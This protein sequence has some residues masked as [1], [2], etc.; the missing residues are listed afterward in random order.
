MTKLIVNTKKSYP[1]YIE[2]N[3]L[4]TGELIIQ[5]CQRLANTW[6]I[7]A[8][9]KLTE[10][11]AKPLLKKLQQTNS[12]TYLL[13][14][15]ACEANKTREQKQLLEDE[16][17]RLGCGRDIC[18]IALGGGVTTDLV[19]FLAAT[20]CRGIPVIYI[21]TSLLAMVDA[22]IG[23]KTGV[24]TP[25]GKNLI[26]CFYQPNAVFIDPT[27]LK[28]LPKNL[29][30]DGIAEVIKHALLADPQLIQLLQQQ[31]H[32]ILNLDTRL[33]IEMI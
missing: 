30:C 32:A 19:G 8:D 1:I 14:F 28:T 25:V 3:L 15:P 33:L 22:S 11:Y 5:H 23:G 17:L 21:P 12:N 13:N 18:L 2:D 4:S 26:G 24:N 20:F 31:A 27:V 6:I 16:L 9:A 10:L 7:I 29:F